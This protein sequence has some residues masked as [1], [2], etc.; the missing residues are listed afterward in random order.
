MLAPHNVNEQK[1]GEGVFDD[2]GDV[3]RR[4]HE[5]AH[6][7]YCSSAAGLPDMAS[8]AVQQSF[9]SSWV[10]LAN[11]LSGTY[12]GWPWMH[13]VCVLGYHMISTSR[14]SLMSAASSNFSVPSL[15]DRLT[16][17]RLAMPMT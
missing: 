6:Q 16:V 7:M 3:P 1:L 10:Y 8:T 15:S 4:P 9:S 11:R 17:D 2:R 12:S 13:R 14:P 5:T